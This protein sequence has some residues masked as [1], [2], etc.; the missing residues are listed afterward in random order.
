MDSAHRSL[1]SGVHRLEHVECLSPANLADDDPI[2]SHAQ[3]V[4]H[5]VANADLAF[6]FDVLWP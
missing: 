3:C 5:E 4:P 1:V 2:R 6:A